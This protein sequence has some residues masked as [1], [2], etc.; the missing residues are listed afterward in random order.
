MLVSSGA[1][2]FPG[3][4]DPEDEGTLRSYETSVT[5]YQ[6]TRRNIPDEGLKLQH[7]RC[8]SVES[9]KRPNISKV[10]KVPP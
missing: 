1:D 3:L 4:L 6:S 8:E 9:R 7:H 5:I 10:Y 2:E